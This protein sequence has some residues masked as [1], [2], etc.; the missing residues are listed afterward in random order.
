MS[1]DGGDI[2]TG[3]P[4]GSVARPFRCWSYYDDIVKFH[5]TFSVPVATKPDFIPFERVALRVSLMREEL[6]ELTTE[7][8]EPDDNLADIAKEGAD[9]IVTVLGTMAEYGI[10]FDEVWNAVCESNLSKLD[11]DGKPIYRPDGKVLKSDLYQPPDIQGILNSEEI[12]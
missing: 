4:V 5:E 12:K 10:P 6:N 1:D 2:L 8:N 3:L 7:M 11:A 9:L